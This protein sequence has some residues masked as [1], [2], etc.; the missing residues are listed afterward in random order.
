MRSKEL[1]DSRR[2]SSAATYKTCKPKALHITEF[3]TLP[4]FSIRKPARRLTAGR[5][6]IMLKRMGQQYNVCGVPPPKIPKTL[7][8]KI[9]KALEGEDE[10]SGMN[11]GIGM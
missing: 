7:K 2:I 4:Y 9:I 8:A 10:E 6:G 11:L 1:T 3:A 5:V